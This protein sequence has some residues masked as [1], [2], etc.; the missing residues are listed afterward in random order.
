[1]TDESYVEVQ[2]WCVEL[3]SSERYRKSVVERAA[4]GTLAPEIEE[5]I[6]SVA[7]NPRPLGPKVSLSDRGPRPAARPLALVKTEL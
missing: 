7:T 5:V 3:L 6:W 1:M 2:R 4:K